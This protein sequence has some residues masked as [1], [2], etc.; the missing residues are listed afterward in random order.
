MTA[1]KLLASY[2]LRE[3]ARPAASQSI[4]DNLTE[5]ARERNYQ[6]ST[7]DLQKA[8]DHLS[9]P[10][11]AGDV[12]LWVV[13]ICFWAH[14]HALWNFMLDAVAS[15]E[16]DSDLIRVAND[17]GVHIL[18]HYGSMFPHFERQAKQDRMFARMVTGIWRHRMSDDVW[19][20]LRQLQREVPDPLPNM[21]DLNEQFDCLRDEDRTKADKGLFVRDQ[22][23]NWT[24]KHAKSG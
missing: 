16:N 21:P 1:E 14:P 11:A 4:L 15:A 20:S 13:Q 3:D 18:A 8:A 17:L 9:V 23:G 24:L 2:W 6:I 12:G 19:K 10:L 22:D 7:S 5:F